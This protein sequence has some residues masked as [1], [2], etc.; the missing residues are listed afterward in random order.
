MNVYFEDW[1]PSYGSPYLIGDDQPDGTASIVE[2][3]AG[4]RIGPQSVTPQH[5]AFVDGV[6]RGEGL[7]YRQ[8]D[9]GQLVRGTVGAYACGSVLCEPGARPTFGAF[10]ARRLCIFG[11]GQSVPLPLTDG[12]EWD[13]VAVQSTEMDAPL[14]EL[15]TRMRMAEGQLAERLAAEGWLVVVDGPLNFVRSRDLPVVG[16]VKTHYRPLLPP[17]QHGAVSTL[18]CGERTPLFVLGTDRYSCYARLAIVSPRQSPWHGIVRLEVPQSAGLEKA[19]STADA[20]TAV[21]PRFAGIPHRDP[22]AP[23]NLQPVGALERQLRRRLGPVR[24][25][26]RAARAAVHRLTASSGAGP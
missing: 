12:Y 8:A 5:T 21:L 17:E 9:G 7:L 25:A 6:R 13:S 1:D 22:R 20:V 11:G 19:R 3:A 4:M 26:S 18:Q 23:Q 15:Q 16:L 2:A 24:L 10:Q 14:Q